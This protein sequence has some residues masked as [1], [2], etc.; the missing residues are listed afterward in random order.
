MHRLGQE[1]IHTYWDN[2][3]PPRLTVEPGDTVVFET[4]E[5]SQGG[6][7]RDITSGQWPVLL[8]LIWSRW[9]C[10]VRLP[11]PLRTPR[12]RSGDMP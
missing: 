7:A 3:L 8:T 1:A 6:V 9:W 4:L 5:P 2:A 10:P 11:S 12:T